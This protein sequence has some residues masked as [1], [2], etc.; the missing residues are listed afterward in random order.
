MAILGDTIQNFTDDIAIGAAFSGNF[1]GMF[2][3]TVLVELLPTLLSEEHIE[4]KHF[5]LINIG[6]SISMSLIFA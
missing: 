6:T 1:I 5:I 2:L 4:S 3:Y